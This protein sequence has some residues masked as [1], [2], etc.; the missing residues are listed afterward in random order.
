MHAIRRQVHLYCI[1]LAYRVDYE[2]SIWCLDLGIEIPVASIPLGL[3]NC[4]TSEALELADQLLAECGEDDIVFGFEN[5]EEKLNWVNSILK[6]EQDKF[7]AGLSLSAADEM[8][9]EFGDDEVEFGFGDEDQK[10]E[11]FNAVGK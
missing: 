4:S 3:R 8:L 10:L 9:K 11:W 5:D 2:P 1:A 6:A 7:M